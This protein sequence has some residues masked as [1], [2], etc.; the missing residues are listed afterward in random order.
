MFGNIT[1]NW[2]RINDEV[3]YSTNYRFFLEHQILVDHP[4]NTVEY[5]VSSR[6]DGKVLE[7][8][9]SMAKDGNFEG[10]ELDL[11]L[12]AIHRKLLNGEIYE[13]KGEFVN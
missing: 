5:I 13:E 1:K 3:E 7:K 8:F 11:K 12:K 4:I 10:F 2:Y 9:N 6:L